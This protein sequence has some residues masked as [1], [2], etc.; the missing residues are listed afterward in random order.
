V[1]AL[2]L[3]VNRRLFPL[4]LHIAVD[5]G[6]LILCG[7]AH[8][9]EDLFVSDRGLGRRVVVH[10]VTGRLARAAAHAQVGVVQQAEAAGITL[11]ALGPGGL[12]RAGSQD[13]H[14]DPLQES[15]PGDGHRDA[16]LA[17]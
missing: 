2:V 3:A 13:T 8:A 1:H 6:E 4:R 16:S 17:E 15:S 7:A 12:G 14:A 11:E 9:L 10:L 5:H